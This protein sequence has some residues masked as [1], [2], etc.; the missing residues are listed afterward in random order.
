MGLVL[1][2]R[3]RILVAISVAETT[4]TMRFIGY[5]LACEHA[6]IGTRQ[7]A[8]ALTFA[9]SPLTCVSRASV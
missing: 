9:T 2:P 4:F 1:A 3:P 8:V 5:E 7:Y 6:A